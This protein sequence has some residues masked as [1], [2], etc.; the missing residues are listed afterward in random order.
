LREMRTMVYLGHHP[1]IMPL[2][3]VYESSEFY[4]QV[5]PLLADDCRDLFDVLVDD[6]STLTASEQLAVGRSLISVMA[7]LH[8]RH[9]AH[10]DLSCENVLV[11]RSQT[12]GGVG[13]CLIDFGQAVGTD[14]MGFSATLATRVATKKDYYVAPEMHR[15]V[16]TSG[17]AVAKAVNGFAVD[18]W[19]LGIVLWMLHTRHPLFRKAS[20]LC[21]IYRTVMISKSW[22]LTLHGASVGLD[23]S[24]PLSGVLHALLKA[25]PTERALISQLS[26]EPYVAEGDAT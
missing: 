12:T 7:F 18:A 25:C 20:P 17:G 6:K 2:L 22:S 13:V 11:V 4:F 15:R 19:A 14:G 10:A 8:S 9:I 21:P 5:M 23:M 16:T 3:A 26:L 1:L 24:G